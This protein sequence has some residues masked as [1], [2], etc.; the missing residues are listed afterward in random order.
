MVQAKVASIFILK[1]AID[2]TFCS[3]MKVRFQGTP[4][5]ETQGSPTRLSIDI[6]IT[7]IC[8]AMSHRYG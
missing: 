7:W 3:R 2:S 1:E 6:L 4:T 5:V 8:S